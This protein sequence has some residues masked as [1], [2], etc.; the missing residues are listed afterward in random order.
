MT[1]EKVVTARHARN[2]YWYDDPHLHPLGVL[3]ALIL[4]YHLRFTAGIKNPTI[5]SSTAR[6]CRNTAWVVRLWFPSTWFTKD[7]VS[8]HEI[9]NISHLAGDTVS[10]E[11]TREILELIRQQSGDVVIITHYQLAN[12]QILLRFAEAESI[13]VEAELEEKTTPG[14]ALLLDLAKKSL[15]LLCGSWTNTC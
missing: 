5:L 13:E 7:P 9:L 3:Q 1:N 8:Y 15:R 6:R 14:S 4:G 2:F 10:E 11:Q 12:G